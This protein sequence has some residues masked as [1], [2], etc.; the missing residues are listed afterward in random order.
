MNDSELADLLRTMA[1]LG[2]TVV[3][4]RS[5]PPPKPMPTFGEFI[6]RLTAAA[7]P[8]M[9]Q[10]YSHYWNI[11]NAE[12]GHRRLDEPTPLDIIALMN[13]HRARAVRRSNWR[14][15]VSATRNL[16]HAL[17]CLYRHAELDDLMPTG[18][19][20]A[21]RVAMPYRLESTRHALLPEQ[22]H[23][24]GRVATETGN[25]PELDALL[26]RLHIETACRR[27]AALRLTRADLSLP[28]STVLLHH[29]GDVH[30]WH[31]ITPLLMRRLIEH[32]DD[33]GADTTPAG[34]NIFRTRTGLP[35]TDRRYDN[36]HT[37]FHHHLPWADAKGVTVHWLRHTT[38]TYVE[39]EFS[40]AVARRYAAHRNPGNTAT[41]LYT[42]ATLNE[43]AHAL[44]ALTGHDHPLAT[45]T[46]RRPEHRGQQ[47]AKGN[48]RVL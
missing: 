44:V 13:Q 20:P 27:E 30:A 36:L 33:R 46:H 9:N 26:V 17:R 16:L 6:P 41:P 29:K 1:R 28:D 12:W 22:V 48:T 32:H 42:R 11:V 7:S 8:V 3:E 43:C 47:A 40:E 37:R 23:E 45:P 15:G 35:I 19:N 2:L 5:A 10:A 39:R 21:L 34:A 31:P 24:L 14:G 38:L 18:A 25:D 4:H